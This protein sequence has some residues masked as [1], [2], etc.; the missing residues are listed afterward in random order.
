[1][2]VRGRN[3]LAKNPSHCADGTVGS[4][5][6]LKIFMPNVGEPTSDKS[7][8]TK[9][10]FNDYLCSESVRWQFTY[11]F[12]QTLRERRYNPMLHISILVL[13]T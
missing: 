2:K 8:Q 12:L 6:Y 1:M 9:D 3:N 10:T 7:I 11:V 13:A 5:Y 4:A